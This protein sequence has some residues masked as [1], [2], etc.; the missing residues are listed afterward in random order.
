MLSRILQL[1]QDGK[2]PSKPTFCFG[3]E[4]V[5]LKALPRPQGAC[6]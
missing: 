1:A 3:A 2:T 6:M 5:L 4:E